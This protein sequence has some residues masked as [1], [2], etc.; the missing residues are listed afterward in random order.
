VGG[1]APAG[2]EP[3]PTSPRSEE[4]G[5]KPSGEGGRSPTSSG[6]MNELGSPCEGDGRGHKSPRQ[7]R[8]PGAGLAEGEKSA[9]MSQK[10]RK[11]GFSPKLL[12]RLSSL[13]SVEH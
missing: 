13:P 3:K 8:R 2:A 11:E 4:R 1:G 9:R 7:T 5:H 6:E 10:V 12:S